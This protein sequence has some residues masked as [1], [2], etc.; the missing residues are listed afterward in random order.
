MANNNTPSPDPFVLE[1][2]I[3]DSSRE[4]TNRRRQERAFAGQRQQIQHIQHVHDLQQVQNV[5]QTHPEGQVQNGEDGQTRPQTEPDQ[6]QVVNETD[7]RDGQ[8]ASSFTHTSGRRRSRSPD[9]EE[10]INIPEG[11]DP[12]AILLLKEL[13]K[14]NRLIRQQGDRIHDLERKRRY[15]SP[16]RRRHRSR[17]Y[18]SSRSA[19]RRSRKRSPSRSRSPS[20][21]NRRQRS[22][23][24]S[25]PRKTRKNQ[26]PET[27]EAK[28][29][30][31]EQEH[32]GPSKA[33]QKV[34]EHSPKDNRKISGKAR[35]KSQR[36]RHSNSPEPSD[37]EDFRSPLSEQIRRVRLP[38][39]ME[40]PPALDHY[41]GTTDPDDHI[42]S[43]EAVMDYHVDL[44]LSHFTASRRQPKSEANL[45]AVI[46]GTNE[47]LRDYL[48]RFNKEAVQV[49]TADYMK[50]YLLE[51]GL[52]PGSDFKKAIK[53]EEVHSMNAL[54][55]KA[56]AFIRYEEAE[57]ATTRASR[58]NDAA[59]SSNHEPSTSRRGHERRKD[60]RSLD[61][62]ERRGPSGRF[63]EYTPLNASRERILA[64]CQNTD[65]KK[66]NIRPPKSNPARPGT[67]KSKKG[68]LPEGTTTETLT[69]GIRRTTGPY[70]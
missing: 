24:R 43:I 33:V 37:E 8:P 13:Q 50:R 16:Q 30:S 63:N 7:T 15:R 21:R 47:S 18:S 3:E 36:G 35:T 6:L 49:Q 44:F 66:S 48:D 45:E 19:P 10:Q 54:L 59:R 9:E 2:L 41:D 65:F 57:A 62:K 51:R 40:K 56:Q 58:D 14:P 32:R 28:S 67:D 70:K 23:S 64:E 26:K 25:P 61:I 39:G 68:N 4:L 31:P 38:R 34:R 20:R 17:S 55:R 12:T 11:A 5:E 42:R 29:L 46:Q 52:L 27:T 1:Q 53:T 60:D 22:Y 69:K